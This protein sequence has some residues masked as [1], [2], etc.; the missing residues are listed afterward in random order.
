MKVIIKKS[1]H[2]WLTSIIFFIFL[3]ENM[4]YSNNNNLKTQTEHLTG[5]PPEASAMLPEHSI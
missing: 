2:R 3:H 1:H 4:I 5:Y